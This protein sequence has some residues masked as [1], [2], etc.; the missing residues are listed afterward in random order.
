[1]SAIIVQLA[2]CALLPVWQ[3]WEV[4]RVL[5]ISHFPSAAYTQFLPEVWWMKQGLRLLAYRMRFDRLDACVLTLVCYK[6]GKSDIVI[7]LWCRTETLARSQ[8]GES[9]IK[10]SD[11]TTTLLENKLKGWMMN[12]DSWVR[13][14]VKSQTVQRVTIPRVLLPPPPLTLFLSFCLKEITSI[15]W[16]F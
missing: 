16:A 1:M 6:F 5:F 9:V 11:K 15:P 2:M 10:L 12:E 3:K 13:I 8:G 14:H 7:Q 4:C